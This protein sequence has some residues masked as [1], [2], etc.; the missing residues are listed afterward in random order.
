MVDAA[1]HW[2]HSTIR[3]GCARL[4]FHT[5]LA[6]KL[7]VVPNPAYAAEGRDILTLALGQLEAYW[8]QGGARPFMTGGKVGGEVQCSAWLALGLEEMSHPSR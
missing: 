8:L 3:A 6:P 7:G 1:L 4:V 5:V 2:Y